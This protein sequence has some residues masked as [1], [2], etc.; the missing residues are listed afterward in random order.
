MNE[1]D[2][3][4][5]LSPPILG[6]ATDDEA[7]QLVAIATIGMCRCLALGAVSTEY[8]C[9]RLFGPALLNRLP[10][11]GAGDSLQDAIHL[12]T[13]LDDVSRL[14]PHALTDSIAEIE[15]LALKSLEELAPGGWGATWSVTQRLG[16]S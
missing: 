2:R 10:E 1:V 11:M 13:E 5:R 4:D 7:Q 9:S 8:A 3:Q 16:E 6:A 14:V 12:A 15:A